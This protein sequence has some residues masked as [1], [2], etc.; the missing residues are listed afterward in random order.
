MST[1]IL[2]FGN[3]C[4]GKSTL[5]AALARRFDGAY[6]SFGDRK[7]EA[8][9][10]GTEAGMA[11]LDATSRE[12]P[13]DPSMGFEVLR[14]ALH[15]RVNF[16][17]GYPI[18]EEELA[19][20]RAHAT[21]RGFIHIWAP[22]STVQERFF[23]RGVCPHCAAPGLIGQRCEQHDFALEARSDRS[24]AQLDTRT[25]LYERRILPFVERLYRAFPGTQIDSSRYNPSDMVECAISWLDLVGVVRDG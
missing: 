3:T 23:S 15:A 24:R 11:I 22:E 16:F 19:C 12:Q 1:A 2:I 9:A 20:V 10:A 18:T 21:V 6:L 13:I 17:S 4:V 5:G 8:I 7:R 25:R 14:P